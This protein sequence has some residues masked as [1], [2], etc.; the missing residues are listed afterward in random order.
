M[1]ASDNKKG[2]LTTRILGLFLTAALPLSFSVI[3]VPTAIASERGALL[4]ELNEK[5]SEISKQSKQPQLI[6]FN[7]FEEPSIEASTFLHEQVATSVEKSE[8]NLGHAQHV[9]WKALINAG[10]PKFLNEQLAVLA[11]ND[12]KKQE[13]VALAVAEKT[14]GFQFFALEFIANNTAGLE[15]AAP[16]VALYFDTAR[17]LHNVM[18]T[19]LAYLN[20]YELELENNQSQ[21]SALKQE[22]EQDYHKLEFGEDGKS[23]KNK[24]KEEI[25][26][27]Y[28]QE[29]A[30]IEQKISD[31]EGSKKNAASSSTKNANHILLLEETINGLRK[32]LQE[33]EA[34]YNEQIKVIDDA[35]ALKKA[36]GDQKIEILA[37]KHQENTDLTRKYLTYFFQGLG[38]SV[39][40]KFFDRWWNGLP[41]N[42]ADF[43]Y[44]KFD[45]MLAKYPEALLD[46]R[47]LMYSKILEAAESHP[48]KMKVY[49]KDIILSSLLSHL[50]FTIEDRATFDSMIEEQQRKPDLL[51]IT[52][53]PSS[54]GGQL[55][56]Q[57]ETTTPPLIK[58]GEI[59]EPKSDSTPTDTQVISD[60]TPI[61]SEK[62]ESK[63][64]ELTSVTQV[65]ITTVQDSPTLTVDKST[66]TGVN[67]NGSKKK[68]GR[69]K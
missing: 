2:M 62:A 42:R 52:I 35:L 28:N 5:I 4:E 39:G 7:K 3:T 27:K 20:L 6:I 47:Y 25:T 40:L 1:R 33:L 57:S 50:G 13:A 26:E 65:G 11:G 12:L 45:L 53:E 36:K 49:S 17:R 19:S 55:Q 56:Q 24:E 67:T 61:I 32:Q 58:E 8:F 60:E 9:L 66:T 68:R 38:N 34:K 43:D 41:Q 15:E 63:K 64:T 10:E 69:R 22:C 31:T 54:T 46:A 48:G 14:Y 23:G 37:K 29:K 51:Q 16:K 18:V 21:L 30:G 44:S 59:V